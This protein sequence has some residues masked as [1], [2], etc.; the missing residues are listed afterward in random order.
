MSE[1]LAEYARPLLKEVKDI[2]SAH[3]VLQWRQYAGIY[4]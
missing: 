4:P 1:V 2:K 3:V